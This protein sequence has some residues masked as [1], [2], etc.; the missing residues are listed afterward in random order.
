MDNWL[1]QKAVAGDKFTQTFKHDGYSG[2]L[3]INLDESFFGSAY[4]LSSEMPK[5]FIF[6]VSYSKKVIDSLAFHGG[7]VQSDKKTGEIVVDVTIQV[8]DG[9]NFDLYDSVDKAGYYVT[10]YMGDETVNMSV[11]SEIAVYHMDQ[12]R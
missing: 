5:T 8:N 6:T 9:E 11:T 2:D 1:K 4:Q 12:F 3:T 10:G 7:Q